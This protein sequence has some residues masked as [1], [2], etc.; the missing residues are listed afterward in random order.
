M[1]SIPGDTHC[2]SSEGKQGTRSEHYVHPVKSRPIPDLIQQL[3]ALCSFGCCFA[4]C[5]VSNSRTNTFDTWSFLCPSEWGAETLLHGCV[6]LSALCQHDRCMLRLWL[7]VCVL[8]E[9]QEDVYTKWETADDALRSAW[10]QQSLPHHLTRR[11]RVTEGGWQAEIKWT[12]PSADHSNSRLRVDWIILSVRHPHRRG[13]AMWSV[14]SVITGSIAQR[15]S[16][17]LHLS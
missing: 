15:R 6:S 8:N 3:Q 1:C 2:L 17:T 14:S 9:L 11:R 10:Q 13:W 16:I 7:R 4:C 12:R 5:L